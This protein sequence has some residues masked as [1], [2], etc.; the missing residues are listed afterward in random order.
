L[1]TLRAQFFPSGAFHPRFSFVRAGEGL[2]SIGVRERRAN[3]RECPGEIPGVFC[4]ASRDFAVICAVFVRAALTRDNAKNPD[5]QGIVW[6]EWQDL[7]LRP[8]RPERGTLRTSYSAYP[9]AYFA[10]P[11]ALTAAACRA[12]L[13]LP[14]NKRSKGAVKW[15]V[16][17]EIF[18]MSYLVQLGGFEPPTS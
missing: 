12:S 11:R 17:D 16:N 15:N 4:R 9:L 10:D 8:P 2:H 18:S 14:R 7:N 3:A 5:L 6:S 13:V 1:H